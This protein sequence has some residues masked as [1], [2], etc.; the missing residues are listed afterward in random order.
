MI[1]ILKVRMMVAIDCSAIGAT[2]LKKSI[3]K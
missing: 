2:F 3:E 1:I